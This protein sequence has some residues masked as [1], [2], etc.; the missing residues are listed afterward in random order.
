MFPRYVTLSQR[1]AHI[2]TEYICKDTVEPELLFLKKITSL[3]LQLPQ[4]A[5]TT[6]NHKMKLV[7]GFVQPSQAPCQLHTSPR[8][9]LLSYLSG[10]KL[11]P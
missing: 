8:T 2:L 5:D 6:K 7:A 4:H 9:L 1:Q 11:Q 3:W 10:C